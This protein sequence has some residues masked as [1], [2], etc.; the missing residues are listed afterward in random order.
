MHSDAKG[1]LLLL[2]RLPTA[3]P[4]VVSAQLC[5]YYSLQ[6]LCEQLLGA[7]AARKQMLHPQEVLFRQSHVGRGS[8]SNI[9]R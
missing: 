7:A 6:R 4:A 9:S 5:D 8:P 3:A 1:D 2:L